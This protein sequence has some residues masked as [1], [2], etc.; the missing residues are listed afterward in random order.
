MREP[1]KLGAVL[2]IITTICGGLLGFI[3]AKT[4]PIIAQ[5]KEKS[6][7]EAVQQLLPSAKEMEEVIVTDTP[8]LETVFVTYDNGTYTG[9]V[10]KVYPD[11]FGGSIELLV[12]MQAD[13]NLAGIQVLSHAETP[14]LG[15]NMTLDSFKEQFPGQV[16]PLEV[17]KTSSGQGEV[18]AITGATIT[19]RAVVD[20]VNVATEYMKAHQANWEKGEY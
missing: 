9:A 4:S 8:S 14:G 16:T 17:S 1:L 13:G 3:N 7:Q 15:A 20:G 5:G 2:L 12:G 6:Q 19:T 10:A 18:M 11:G